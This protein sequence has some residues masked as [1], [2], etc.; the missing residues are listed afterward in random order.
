MYLGELERFGYTLTV[1]SKTKKGAR[2]ALMK[3]Y[4]KT[5]IRCNN[6]EIPTKDYWETMQDEIMIEKLAY[7]EILWH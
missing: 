4:L 5:Y 3:E 7:D 2:R 6:G 1:I